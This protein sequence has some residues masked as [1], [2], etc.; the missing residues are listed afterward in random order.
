MNGIDAHITGLALRSGFAPLADGAVC[1]LGFAHHRAPAPIGHRAAQIVQM[2]VRQLRQ[3]LEP[4]IAEHL[5]LAPHQ[6]HPL[7]YLCGPDFFG[8][9]QLP[10]QPELRVSGRRP[11]ISGARRRRLH[12]PRLP[13][14]HGVGFRR[15]NPVR[16]DRVGACDRQ[17]RSGSMPLHRELLGAA[18]RD[19]QADM[20]RPDPAFCRCRWNR[21]RRE[22]LRGHVVG[23][24]ASSAGCLAA[25]SHHRQLHVPHWFRSSV[26]ASAPPASTS[27]AK[28]SPARM[29][30]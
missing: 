23:R 22:V 19:L 11:A 8:H 27:T 20:K 10:R 7:Q 1:R 17:D 30:R 5:V 14:R 15:S 12:G 18:L 9:L 2:T 29:C 13:D 24:S 25:S 16:M 6:R 4:P 3:S 21:V 26:R 28:C